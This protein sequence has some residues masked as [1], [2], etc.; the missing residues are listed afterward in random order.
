[1]PNIWN[2]LGYETLLED[3]KKAMGPRRKDARK[4]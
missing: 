2:A 1:M 3:G 4:L